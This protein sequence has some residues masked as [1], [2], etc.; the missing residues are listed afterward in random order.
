MTPQDKSSLLDIYSSLGSKQEPQQTTYMLQFLWRDLTSKF[1]V[2]GLY[3]SSAESLKSKFI[4]ACLYK[5]MRLCQ[6]YGLQTSAVVCDGASANP[7][8][9]ENSN[10]VF[11]QLQVHLNSDT[12]FPLSSLRILSILPTLFTGLSVPAIRYSFIPNFHTLLH[13]LITCI[14]L[15]I[16]HS[17]PNSKKFSHM[18]T[19][20]VG[21][22]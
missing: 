10:R 13:S 18:Y 2:M 9:V 5:T 15:F 20:I 22:V 14:F 19:T 17:I 1:D 7:N 11:K 8:S 4:L 6:L 3:Y 12:L 16:I 21:I